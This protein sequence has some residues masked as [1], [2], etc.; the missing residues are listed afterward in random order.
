[1]T[2]L[3]LDGTGASRRNDNAALGFRPSLRDLI[4]FR[5]LPSA[6]ALGYYRDAPPGLIS[7]ELTWANNNKV[8]TGRG[9]GRPRHIGTM[10][11][12]RDIIGCA[13]ERGALRLRHAFT[14]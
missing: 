10:R 11:T 12:P 6:E 4:L 1:M 13:R 14:S 3:A 9:R 5:P 2:R 7:F 8:G